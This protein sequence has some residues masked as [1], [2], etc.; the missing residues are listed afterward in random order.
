MPEV[1]ILPGLSPLARGNH[2]RSDWFQMLPGPIP[3]RA[4]QPQWSRSHQPS[5]A[6]YPRSRG[7]TCLDATVLRAFEGLS[8]LARGNRHGTNRPRCRARPI[9]A[10]A[11]QPGLRTPLVFCYGAYPRSRGA[12][13][14][15]SQEQAHTE[16][17]SP[18]ARGNRKSA[19]RKT[20]ARGPIPARAGQPPGCRLRQTD[21]RAY[22]RS[23]GATFTSESFSA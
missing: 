22:P 6:A 4:G 17:L 16:G 5:L 1:S 18:L 20:M 11:G 15:F 19:K 23:R 2:A 3:A 8:P 14:I 12:T 13:L 9:P 21:V 7:A 10:R